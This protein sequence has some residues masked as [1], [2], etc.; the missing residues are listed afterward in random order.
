MVRLRKSIQA[1][2]SSLIYQIRTVKQTFMS[3]HDFMPWP[4]FV[5]KRKQKRRCVYYSI[6]PI[7][8]TVRLAFRAILETQNTV[9]LIG[10]LRIFTN[11][12]FNRNTGHL[13]TSSSNFLKYRSY[14]YK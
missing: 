5:I 7:K 12:T 10:I 4:S 11:S 8:R 13:V 3:T 14:K 1:S 9:R 6:H 2:I